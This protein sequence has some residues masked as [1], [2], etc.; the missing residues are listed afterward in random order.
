MVLRLAQ[1]QSLSEPVLLMCAAGWPPSA[2]L[3]RWAKRMKLVLLMILPLFAAG[4]ASEEV[5]SVIKS[6]DKAHEVAV[7]IQDPGALGARST[8]LYLRKFGSRS[9][10]RILVVMYEPKIDVQWLDPKNVQIAIPADADVRLEEPAALGIRIV[11][12]PL[13]PP[14]DFMAEADKILQA[15]KKAQPNAQHNGGDRPLTNDPPASETP[16]S[17]APRG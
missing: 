10:P 2:H 5:V 9:G 16:S 15:Q 7:S 13:I 14:P 8:A 17:P 6:T 11:R 12:V 3:K 1:H 4:C